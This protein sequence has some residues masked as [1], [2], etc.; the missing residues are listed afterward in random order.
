MSDLQVPI[1]PVPLPFLPG[2]EKLPQFRDSLASNAAP[3]DAEKVA[4]DFESVLLH[5]LMDQMQRTIPESGLL[6]SGITKQAQGL[7]W[8]YLAQEIGSSGGLGLWQDIYRKIAR[9]V[10][11]GS[12]SPIVEEQH[13]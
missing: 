7:F 13:R 6:S 3:R 5:K 1:N 12:A 11:P 8:H 4:K 2:V 9:P 10:Q